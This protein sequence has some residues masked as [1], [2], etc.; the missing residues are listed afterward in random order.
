MFANAFIANA[1]QR[2]KKSVRINTLWAVSCIKQTFLS[3]YATSYDRKHQTIV[4]GSAFIPC[5]LS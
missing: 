1:L 4:S 2:Y 5:P 3:N